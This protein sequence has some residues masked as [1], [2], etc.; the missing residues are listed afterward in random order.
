MRKILLYAMATIAL[1][2]CKENFSE[3]NINADMGRIAIDFS[4]SGEVATRANE[5]IT[6]TNLPTAAAFALKITGSAS[7][8]VTSSFSK[9]WSSF[10]GYNYEEERLFHGLYDVT[11]TYGDPAVEGYDKPAFAASATKVEV[12]NKNKT[13]TLQMTATLANAIVT[14]RTTDNFN[15]YFPKSKFSITTATDTYEFEKENT[16]HLFIAP[17][18]NVKINCSCVRQNNLANDTYE[19]LAP[20]T[21]P[22]VVAK[23]HYVVTYDL[24]TAGS[25]KITIKLNDEPIGTQVINTEINPNA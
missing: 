24:T 10:A 8:A 3:Q 16:S 4:T 14:I 1:V 22:S 19:T 12:E 20:Q 13:T 23:T 7:D 25:V 11:L 17:Q 6:L 9:E 5:G 2:G 21:I 15:G 18:Q